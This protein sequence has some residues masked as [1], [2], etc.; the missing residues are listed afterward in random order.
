MLK[1][2]W[3]WVVGRK[4]Y[5]VCKYCTAKA[6]NLPGENPSVYGWSWNLLASGWVCPNQHIKE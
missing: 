5:T 3:N 4:P 6:F 2:F 1:T